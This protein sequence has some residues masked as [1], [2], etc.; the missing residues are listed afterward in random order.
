MKWV[1]EDKARRIVHDDVET[2]EIA[3]EIEHRHR[4]ASTIAGSSLISRSLVVGKLSARSRR[5]VAGLKK[6]VSGLR[7]FRRKLG[8]RSFRPTHGEH[9]R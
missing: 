6:N 4:E 1:G 9:P 8:R 3:R 7:I 5:K 2:R